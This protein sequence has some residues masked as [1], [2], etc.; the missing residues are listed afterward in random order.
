[1]PAPVRQL[2]VAARAPFRIASRRHERLRA[3][4]TNEIVL[5]PHGTLP[6][7]FA[8]LQISRRPPVGQRKVRTS[9]TYKGMRAGRG[10]AIYP[11]R[12]SSTAPHRGAACFWG[13]CRNRYG[14]Q[15][16][17]PFTELDTHMKPK[18]KK[19]AVELKA[20]LMA[21]VR[22]H[23]ECSHIMGVAIT[24]LMQSAPHQ[25]GWAPNWLCGGSKSA[26]PIADEI[27]RTFQSEFDFA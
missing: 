1:M 17:R 3:N 7:M 19:T 5:Y 11:I 14:V 4:S 6:T 23:P 13:R 21:E 26:P 8:T 10:V 24:R 27:G 15:G 20:L 25:P 2:I 16:C 18:Q 22:K 12:E 9:V